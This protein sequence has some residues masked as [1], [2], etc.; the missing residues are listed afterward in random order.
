MVAGNGYNYTE[1]D[2]TKSTTGDAVLYVLDMQTDAVLAKL[3]YRRRH[4][5]RPA[6]S[7]KI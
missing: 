2:G 6:R 4:D 7:A 5:K 3:D 1:N